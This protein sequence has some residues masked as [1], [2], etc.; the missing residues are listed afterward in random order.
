M[1]SKSTSEIKILFPPLP[2]NPVNPSPSNPFPAKKFPTSTGHSPSQGRLLSGRLEEHGDHLPLASQINHL[3]VLGDWLVN[4]SPI[5][6]D[7]FLCQLS[8]L[9]EMSQVI[10]D[11]LALICRHGKNLEIGFILLIPLLY[12]QD[13]AGP[14]VDE[15]DLSGFI[16]NQER[17]R[18]TGHNIQHV[19]ET[20]R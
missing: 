12:L 16:L 18:Q 13:F 14:V 6:K 17:G 7:H 20:L 8:T 19:L 2:Q 4:I 9:F 15:N 10:G 11:E 5:G 1:G 3:P